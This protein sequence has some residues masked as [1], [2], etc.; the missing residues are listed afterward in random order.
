MRPGR[1]EAS[2]ASPPAPCLL[3]IKGT[4]DPAPT[5]A[6]HRGKQQCPSGAGQPDMALTRGIFERLCSGDPSGL[7]RRDLKYNQAALRTAQG[8]GGQSEG[9]AWEGLADCTASGAAAWPEG[10]ASEF[11]GGARKLRWRLKGTTVLRGVA[12]RVRGGAWEGLDDRAIRLCRGHPLER[13]GRWRP[14]GG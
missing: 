14:P 7:T 2:A 1:P 3:G 9:R 12:N 5:C 8:R 10:G 4:G 6:S 13:P 11:G